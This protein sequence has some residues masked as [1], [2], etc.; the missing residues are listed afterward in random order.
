MSA[1]RPRAARSW[2]L[3]IVLL[4]MASCAPGAS[5]AA[6]PASGPG[7]SNPAAKP[8][9]GASLAAQAAIGGKIA[10]ARQRNIWVFSGSSAQQVTT[11]GGSADPAWSPDGKTLAFDK[12][13]KNSADLYLMPYPQG[14]AKALTNNASRIVENNFWEMQPDWSP[15]GSALIYTSDRGRARTGTLDP[16]VWRMVLASGAKSQ[17]SGSNRYTGGTDFPRWRP[18]AANQIL[19]TS[20]AYDPAS[21]QPYG[22]LTLLNTSTNRSD[23]LTPSGLTELQPS[24]S[25]DGNSLTFVRRQG[26]NDEIWIREVGPGGASPTAAVTATDQPSQAE[27]RQLVRGVNAHPAWAPDGHAVA[28]IGLQDGSFDLFVQPLT[29]DLRLDGAPKQLTRGAHL[30]A[31]SSI[32]WAS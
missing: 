9:A 23:T 8:S 25:P 20:W 12:Q 31:D 13:D 24:W 18:H 4:A 17:L 27:A 26:S 29:A 3:A 11:I 14:P 22:E 1:V 21:L 30:D 6:A 19:Y 28:Y 5:P 16:T 7:A 2:P 15:D 32:S 10:F